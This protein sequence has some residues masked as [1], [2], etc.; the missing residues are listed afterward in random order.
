MLISE[1]GMRGGRVIPYRVFVDA[2]LRKLDLLYRSVD[3]SQRWRK[4]ELQTR[5]GQYHR[6]VL[7]DY[8]GSPYPMLCYFEV[9]EPGGGPWARLN[10][11]ASS[12]FEGEN[13]A[14]GR[15]GNDLLPLAQVCDWIRANDPSRVLSPEFFAGLRVQREEIALITAAEE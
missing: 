6:S 7:P 4:Q 10:A 2:S 11:G 8:T 14:A 9:H 1:A 5:D 12:S 15:D 13:R 3:H